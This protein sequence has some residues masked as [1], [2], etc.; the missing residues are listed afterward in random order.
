M[1][2]TIFPIA[3]SLV[4]FIGTWSVYGIAYS[5]GHVCS[6][7]DWDRDYCRQN[8]SVNC[9]LVP[10]ISSSG[11]NAPENSLFSAT[12]NAGAFLFLLF[13]MFHHAHIME[14]HL[15]HSTLS[16]FALVC[17]TVAALGAFAAGNCNPGF[18]P[19]LHY[20]G[21]AISFACICFYTVLLTSLTG[22][23]A[24]TG[25]EKSLYPL[26]VASTVLQAI[27][28]LLYAVM[29]AQQ[30]DYYAHLSAMFEWMLSINLELFELSY[31]VE[32]YYFSSFMLSN[33]L[34]TRE[35]VKPLMLTMS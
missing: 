25:Y 17:G 29:F 26:R 20:L 22:K 6:L 23:C 13:C 21:A 19:F 1:L 4:S 10:T 34:S 12:V 11:I 24:L 28:T 33:L 27:V 2:W 5:N 7:S 16:R 35:E 32:F 14:R 18:L 3:L 30:E 31:L 9:C 8:K 15:C